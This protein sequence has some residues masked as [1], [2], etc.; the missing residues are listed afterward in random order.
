MKKFIRFVKNHILAI[1]GIMLMVAIAAFIFIFVGNKKEEPSAQ[2]VV[3]SDVQPNMSSESLAEPYA[4]DDKDS[5][6]EGPIGVSRPINDSK[7]NSNKKDLF[8]SSSPVKHRLP[9]GSPSSVSVLSDLSEDLKIP[10]SS[11]ASSEIVKPQEVEEPKLVITSKVDVL[12]ATETN[13]DNSSES[14]ENN[15]E[16]KASSSVQPVPSSIPVAPPAPKMNIKSSE[17]KEKSKGNEDK[18]SSNLSIKSDQPVSSSIPVAPP[19]PN[20]FKTS[21]VGNSFES[22]VPIS[23]DNA[24]KKV[25][26]KEISNSNLTAVAGG[27]A[28]YKYSVLYQVLPTNSSAVDLSKE[29]KQSEVASGKSNDNPQGKPA[30]ITRTGTKIMPSNNDNEPQSE[31]LNN[32]LS[33]ELGRLRLQLQYSELNPEDTGYWSDEECNESSASEDK[34]N[35]NKEADEEQLSSSKLPENNRESSD[36]P[37]PPLPFTVGDLT[38]VKLKKLSTTQE[39]SQGQGGLFGSLLQ[40]IDKAKPFVP[41]E[42]SNVE[43]GLDDFK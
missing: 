30:A 38:S 31:P 37:K 27:G 12:P 41:H 22:P 1:V 36:I 23:M 42:E 40:N 14:K 21:K 39:S 13:V 6:E 8:K 9:S 28:S 29:Q 35:E 11:E 24:K 2:P 17:P 16:Y 18:T 33:N 10:N 7:M 25:N 3:N 20:N 26:S 34:G 19:V 15:N 5:F 4:K 32:T 43:N